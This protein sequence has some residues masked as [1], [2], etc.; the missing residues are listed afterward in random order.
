MLVIN[1]APVLVH[2]LTSSTQGAAIC[3]A[4]RGGCN[5]VVSNYSP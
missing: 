3:R 1:Y 5:V 2:F 4:M